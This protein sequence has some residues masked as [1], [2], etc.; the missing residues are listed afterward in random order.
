MTMQLPEQRSEA[1]AEHGELVNHGVRITLGAHWIAEGSHVFRSAEFDVF[2]EAHD[3]DAA[4]AMFIDNMYDHLEHLHE[5]VRAHDATPHE[6]EAFVTLSER[7]VDAARRHE[8]ER[9]PAIALNFL[10]R[11]RRGRAW[12]SLPE[13]SSTL[14]HA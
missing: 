9:E 4:L 2:A 3:H 10:R 11:G 1:L 13:N 12:R 8:D 6:L 7:F 14:S 5:L